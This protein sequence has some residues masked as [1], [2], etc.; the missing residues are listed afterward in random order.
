MGQVWEAKT[1]L[2]AAEQGAICRHPVKPP[3]TV[4]HRL[5]PDTTRLKE[6]L[7]S[8]GPYSASI[9]LSAAA[10]GGEPG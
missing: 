9:V 8:S 7:R 3:S 10:D 2:E 4:T 5:M 1:H 6:R